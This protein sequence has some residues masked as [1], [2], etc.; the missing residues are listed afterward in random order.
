MLFSKK[1]LFFLIVLQRYY[2]FF[3]LSSIL[4]TFFVFFLNPLH[5]VVILT[6]RSRTVPL[7]CITTAHPWEVSYDALNPFSMFILFIT[8]LVFC[9]ENG[10]LFDQLP[11]Y[12][13]TTMCMCLLTHRSVR[14]RQLLASDLKGIGTLN[15][16]L[17]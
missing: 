12:E 1:V 3:N 7:Y 2:K 13:G 17:Q 5:S 8:T 6:I 11:S 14:T 15:I 10:F 4:Q 16:G 9:S